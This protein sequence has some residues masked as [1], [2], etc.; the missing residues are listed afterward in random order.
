MKAIEINGRMAVSAL[1]DD[2]KTQTGGTLRVKDGGRKADESATLASIRKESDNKGGAFALDP[3]MTVCDFKTKM[4]SDYGLKV[5]V[6][7]PDDWVS[8]PDGITLGQLRELPK[9]A[10]KEQLNVLLNSSEDDSERT[11][12]N[13]RDEDNEEISSSNAQLPFSGEYKDG[14]PVVKMNFIDAYDLE[15]EDRE[16][17]KGGIVV[18]STM[19]GG[20]YDDETPTGIWNYVKVLDEDE[21]VGDWIDNV[22]GDDETRAIG[23]IMDYLYYGG[24]YRV[25]YAEVDGATYQQK[26]VLASFLLGRLKPEQIFCNYITPDREYDGPEAVIQIYYDGVLDEEFLTR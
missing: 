8:V 20:G 7:T 18:V 10:T 11:D 21:S 17:A 22:G 3:E 4:L 19:P 2:F 25:H 9:N 24:S 1:K 14:K 13:E 5:E 16:K 15:D 12:E 26:M 23:T 6:G